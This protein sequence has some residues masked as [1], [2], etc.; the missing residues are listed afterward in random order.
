MQADG[1]STKGG[2]R[3]Q[4]PELYL[5]LMNFVWISLGGSLAAILV[6]A[7][8]YLLAASVS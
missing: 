2:A 3:D 8:S 7:G 5:P 6:G 1:I 4:T